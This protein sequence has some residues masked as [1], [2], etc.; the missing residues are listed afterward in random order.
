MNIYVTKCIIKYIQILMF[1]LEWFFLTFG[2]HPFLILNSLNIICITV[3]SGFTFQ[4]CCHSIHVTSPQNTNFLAS[5]YP[6]SHSL[7]HLNSGNNLHI[8]S[9]KN[10]WHTQIL[11]FNF[12]IQD[13]K[14][15]SFE[16]HASF[17]L[18][19]PCMSKA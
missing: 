1:T 11:R 6:K 14:T 17:C 3:Q 19:C 7:G 9:K 18:L 15:Y 8:D 5:V 13:F 4:V 16:I 12:S 2:V 10:Q